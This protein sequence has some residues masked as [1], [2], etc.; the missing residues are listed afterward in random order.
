GR[1]S[2]TEQSSF[3]AQTNTMICSA[4]S[5]DVVLDP[6]ERGL[7]PDWGDVTECRVA[8]LRSASQQGEQPIQQPVPVDRMPSCWY[9]LVTSGRRPRIASAVARDVSRGTNM[10]SWKIAAATGTSLA[11]SASGSYSAGKSSQ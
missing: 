6:Q 5:P 1:T 3:A 10:S 11:A 4:C 2:G 7:H 8:S 9:S